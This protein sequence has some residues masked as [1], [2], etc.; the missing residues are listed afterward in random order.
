MIGYVLHLFYLVDRKLMPIRKRAVGAAAFEG[1]RKYCS[2]LG[3]PH[4][5]SQV[6]H[7]ALAD[8]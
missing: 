6:E 4:T 5:V 1:S 2:Y 8:F 7:A 3:C